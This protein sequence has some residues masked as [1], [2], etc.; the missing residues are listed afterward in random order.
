M[1]RYLCSVSI[2]FEDLDSEEEAREMFMD[3]V[4][5]GLSA[6]EVDVTEEEP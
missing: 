3:Y 1:P 4:R 6:R 2:D 5:T